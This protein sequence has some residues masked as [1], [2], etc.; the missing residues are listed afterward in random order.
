MESDQNAPPELSRAI[1]QIL[2]NPQ[3]IATVASVLKGT[4]QTSPPSEPTPSPAAPSSSERS[5]AEAEETSSPPTSPAASENHSPPPAID[6]AAMIRSFAPLLAGQTEKGNETPPPPEDRQACLLRALKPYLS[7]G[8][9]E[10]IDY[11]IRLTQIT[12]LLKHMIS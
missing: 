3:L 6:A 1:E 5:D 4:P 10:A 7:P 11:M 12:E 8:R 2:A 9:Q